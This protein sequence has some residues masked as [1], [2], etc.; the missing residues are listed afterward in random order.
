VALQQVETELRQA[1]LDEWAARCRSS[2]VRKPAG[3][4]FGIIQAAI[5]GEFKAW[6][7]QGQRNAV[8]A[9]PPPATN[10]RPANPEVVQAHLAH[11]HALLNQK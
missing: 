11:L 7:G 2:E 1:V 8:A 4:L 3:Y 9:D 6:A 10:P 5:R